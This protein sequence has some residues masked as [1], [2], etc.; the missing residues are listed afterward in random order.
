M[1]TLKRKNKTKQ[2]LVRS[3]LILVSLVIAFASVPNLNNPVSADQYDEKIKSLQ[4][5]IKKYQA[6]QDKLSKQA[7]TLESTLAQLSSQASAIQA[8]IDISQAKYNKLVA[9]IKETEK[10]IKNHKDALG[11]TIADL[12]VGDNITPIEMLASSS[13]IGDYLDKQEIK[14]SVR[15]ELTSAISKIKALKKKLDAEKKDVAKTLSDQKNQKIALV[16]KQDEQQNLLNRTKGDE[17]QYQALISNSLSAIAEARAIQAALRS[18][19]DRTG[20][21]TLLDGG[22]LSSYITD[23]R[24]GSWND[25]SCPMGGYVGGQYLEFASTKGSDGNGGDNRGYGCRQCASYVA[26]K[27]N[28]ATGFYPEWGNAQDFDNYAV[29]KFGYSGNAPRAG[30]IAVMDEGT[31]G[32]VAWVETDPYVNNEG[33]TV[34]QVSQYNWNFGTG[35]GMYSLMELSVNFFDY[36]VQIVK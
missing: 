27:I 34:I 15:D 25:Y 4:E 12:Y 24:Y 19:G 28:Q 17:A 31:Y 7:I 1:K 3:G 30:S 23:S 5:D 36:Y 33:R 32:H 29:A 9:Q 6:E 16:T 10:D 14:N 2:Y 22:L 11:I 26:W 13:T 20:G 18:R 8:Q 21:Y 35:W